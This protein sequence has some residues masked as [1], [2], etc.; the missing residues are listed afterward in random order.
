MNSCRALPRLLS[1]LFRES[2]QSS[3]MR[4]AGSLA[5]PARRVIAAK[6]ARLAQRVNLALREIRVTLVA[7]VWMLP[8]RQS[9]LLAL[10]RMS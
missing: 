2:L 5:R 4:V 1:L 3:H 7:M 9:K 6:L 10:A 8:R